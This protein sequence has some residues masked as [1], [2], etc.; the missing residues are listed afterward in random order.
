[1]GRT[2][3][4][5]LDIFPLKSSCLKTTAITTLYEVAD[6]R[7]PCCTPDSSLNFSVYLLLILALA[8]VSIRINFIYLFNFIIQ[9]IHYCGYRTCHYSRNRKQSTQV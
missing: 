5:T 9:M 2:L 3:L 7:S 1:M 6:G 4:E 8:L